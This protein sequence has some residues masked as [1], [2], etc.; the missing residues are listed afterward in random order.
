MDI[1][2]MISSCGDGEGIAVT[3]LIRALSQRR[4]KKTPC[5]GTR[6]S[7]PNTRGILAKILKTSLNL[8]WILDIMAKNDKCSLRAG[9]SAPAT[10]LNQ[11]ALHANRA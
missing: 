7:L 10:G 3:N 8:R 2:R 5:A 4:D 1:S 11:A 9:T 6:K